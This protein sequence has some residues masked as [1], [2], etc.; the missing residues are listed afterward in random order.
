[1]LPFQCLNQSAVVVVGI[2]RMLPKVVELHW[3]ISIHPCRRSVVGSAESGAGRGGAPDGQWRSIAIATV[4]L[5][6]SRMLLIFRE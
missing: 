3:R 5:R 4:L 1:M 6:R 2:E